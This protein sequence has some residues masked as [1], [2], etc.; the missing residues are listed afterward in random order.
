MEKMLY[1]PAFRPF[2]TIEIHPSGWL[3]RQ[4]E[5]QA[6]GL[7]GHLDEFWPDIHD[8]QWIGGSCEGWERV[9]YW[10]DGFLPLAWLLQRDDLKQ[11]AQRYIDAIL[12][13]QCEDGWLCPCSEEERAN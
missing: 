1:D 4:L 3:H 5:I 10:L 6:E 2:P 12:D 8:S 9:P 7:S 11:K 13:R